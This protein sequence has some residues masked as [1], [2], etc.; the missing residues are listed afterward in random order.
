MT[1]VRGF[2]F[3]CFSICIA[4]PHWPLLI[5][6]HLRSP[7]F[8]LVCRPFV[9]HYSYISHVLV[10]CFHTTDYPYAQCFSLIMEIQKHVQ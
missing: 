7:F 6:Y 3:L 10:P 2:F 4:D 9:Q 5:D 1:N 8:Y